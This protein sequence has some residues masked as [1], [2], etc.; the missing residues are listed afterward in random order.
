[1][2]CWILR[3]MGVNCTRMGGIAKGIISKCTSLMIT[4]LTLLNA[5]AF[6]EKLVASVLVAE[7]PREVSALACAELIRLTIAKA[8][9]NRGGDDD[10]CLAFVIKELKINK[11]NFSLNFLYFIIRHNSIKIKI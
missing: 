4:S 7:I 8:D 11:L 9:C 10:N 1:M 3:L 6:S 5:E 2:D